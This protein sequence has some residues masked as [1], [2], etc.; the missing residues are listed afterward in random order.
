LVIAGLD[1]GGFHWSGTVPV[2]VHIGGLVGVVATLGLAAWAVS[3]NRFFSPVIRIQEERGHHLVTGGL[4]RFVRQPGYLAGM[5]LFSLLALGSW[6]ALAPMG[7]VVF[8]MLR[9]AIRED[10]FLRQELDGYADYAQQVRFRLVPG[11]W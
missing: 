3:V 5:S 9:R 10:R 7:S 4:Y 8:L 11:I 6:W 2:V 1:V